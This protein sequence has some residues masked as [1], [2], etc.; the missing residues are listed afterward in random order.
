MTQRSDPGRVRPL[1]QDAVSCTSDPSGRRGHL[2]LIADGMGGEK[3]G[4]VAS[5]I[6]V[7]VVAEVYFA[8]DLPPAEALRAALREANAR[9][10]HAAAR[11]E[12][13]GMGTTCSALALRDGEAWTAHVG[14]S[15]IY[16]LRRGALERL[17]R[18][19]SLWAQ[20]VSEQG[21]S[22]AH[23]AGQNI[24][25]R[26]LGNPGEIEIDVGPPLELQ[27]GDRFVLCSDGLWDLVTDP[28]IA[29]AA[30]HTSIDTACESLVDL[31]NA[32]GGHDNIS[33]VLVHVA[34]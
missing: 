6:A 2:L 12:R 28:E 23:R 14:D 10:H 21:I 19:H 30:E 27:D 31:A 4:E 3:A 32:R 18:V 13:R 17:T 15:R 29:A 25:M 24:L 20:H 16:R 8:A 1:N 22:P 5:R 9:I 34:G 7:D 26:T 11:P 33:V